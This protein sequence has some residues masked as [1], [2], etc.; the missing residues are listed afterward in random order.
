MSLN[1]SVGI[2]IIYSWCSELNIPVRKTRLEKVKKNPVCG[3]SGFKCWLRQIFYQPVQK[4]DICE[5]PNYWIQKK[6]K[7]CG[8]NAIGVTYP[9]SSSYELS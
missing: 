8:A 4:A 5:Y 3:N 7:I 2:H 9:L 1:V 6:E